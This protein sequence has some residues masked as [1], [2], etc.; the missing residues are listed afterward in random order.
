MT[1]IAVV[2]G[3]NQ[4]LG[5][6]L[7]RGLAARLAPED[8]VLLTGR[9]AGR[10]AAAAARVA[11]DPATRSRV[12]GRVLDVTDS[13]AVARFAGSPVDIV[14]SN[15]VGPLDPG[16][17]QAE[18]ADVFL[19]VANSG[20]HAVLRS[21]GPV[22]RPGGRL[23]VVA[24][25]LGTLGHLPEPLRARFDDVSLDDVEKAVED[26]RA[27]IHDGTA[28]ARGWPDWINVPSKVAQVAAVRAVAA[29]RRDADLANG[30]LVAAVCPGLVDTR[31]SRPWF[32]DFSQAQTPDEAARAVLDLVFADVDPA[33]YGELVRFGRVLPWRTGRP[34]RHEEL[35]G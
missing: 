4:G 31:A 18:Q 26:W 6:A 14:L 35:I 24:S 22:L 25:S 33:T 5:F 10:V 13:A 16:R 1:R 20:T 27:A 15:A 23:L 30:T 28:R 17:P 11:A 9:D 29:R 32:R 12:E 3:A 2:T 7:V 34:H 21:F 19:D 8:L